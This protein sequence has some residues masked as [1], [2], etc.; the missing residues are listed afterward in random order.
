MEA[1]FTSKDH[2]ANHGE[3]DDL[4]CALLRSLGYGDGVAVFEAGYKWYA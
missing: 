1:A 2:E 4:M 3:A